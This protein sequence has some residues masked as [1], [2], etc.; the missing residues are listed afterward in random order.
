[1][2]WSQAYLHVN[3]NKCSFSWLYH[4]FFELLLLFCNFLFRGLFLSMICFT[5]FISTFWM[6]MLMTAFIMLWWILLI[7][8][9]LNC[10]LN[11]IVGVLILIFALKIKYIYWIT[12]TIVK[13]LINL[14]LRTIIS[15]FV[16]FNWF[17]S[18]LFRASSPCIAKWIS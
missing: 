10:F 3:V 6:A 12:I 7:I 18:S 14:F 2:E 1:V 15:F 17:L 9:V 4:L 5:A 13:I 16:S 8:C 11:F